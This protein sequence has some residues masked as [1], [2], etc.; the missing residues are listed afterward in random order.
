MKIR[1]VVLLLLLAVG[2]GGEGGVRVL[3]P[4]EVPDDLYGSPSPMP[5]EAPARDVLVWFVE[6]SRLT[7][8]VRPISGAGGR[9]EFALRSV[10]EGPTPAERERGLRTAVPD[11]AELLEVTVENAVSEVNL[12]K[13]FELGAEQ[14]ELLLRVGQIVYTVTGI[15]GVRRVRF[16]I[17]GEP[18]SVLGEDG[19]TRETV[20]R[21]H[22]A[23][24]TLAPSPSP[25]PVPT[26][27]EGN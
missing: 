20:T 22:Y 19:A 6:G 3:G 5:T 21:A 16:L 11:G 2:C 10:L 4:D 14:R 23:S 13:E 7:S 18:A 26:P 15:G 12:S 27:T 24:L 8:V 17:D 25:T 9:P 1:V